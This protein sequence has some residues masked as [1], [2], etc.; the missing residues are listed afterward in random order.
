MFRGFPEKIGLA[1]H[2]LAPSN[3]FGCSSKEIKLGPLKTRIYGWRSS[4][5]VNWQILNSGAPL[6]SVGDINNYGVGHPSAS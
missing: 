6:I 2:G 4:N 1:G 3:E 5:A